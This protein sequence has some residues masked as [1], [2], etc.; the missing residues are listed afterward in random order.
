MQ[1][2]YFPEWLSGNFA[3]V[4]SWTLIHSLW[5][6]LIAAVSAGL[7]LTCTRHSS[8]QL[9][10]NLLSWIFVLFLLAA[11][12]VFFIEYGTPEP[13]SSALLANTPS[14]VGVTPQAS[15]PAVDLFSSKA[16]SFE[17]QFISFFNENAGIIVLIW[18]FFLLVRSMKVIKDIWNAYRLNIVDV[19]TPSQSWLKK[20]SRLKEKLEI[21]KK[22]RLLES[23]RI[24]VPMTMGY[25]KATILVPIG[26]LA[27]LPS[28]QV[29]AILLH[30]LAHIKRKDFIMNFMQ[31]IA[32]TVFFFNPAVLWISSKIREEREAC[33]DDVVVENLQEK[34]S[35]LEALISFQEYTM[36]TGAYAIGLVGGKN[37]LLTRVKRLLTSENKKLDA[38]EKSILILC[39]FAITAFSFIPRDSYD[40]K[41]QT[42]LQNDNILHPPSMDTTKVYRTKEHNHTD[43]VPFKKRLKPKPAD[44]GSEFISIVYDRTN[45]PGD[46]IHT[47]EITDRNADKFTIT[48]QNSHMVALS[49]NG[50]PIAAVQLTA[51]QNLF[52]RAEDFIRQRSAEKSK[53]KLTQAEDKANNTLI[54]NNNAGKKDRAAA[55]GQIE[56]NAAKNKL[57]SNNKKFDTTIAVNLKKKELIPDES[58]KRDAERIKGVLQELVNEGVVSNTSLVEWFGITDSKMMVNGIEVPEALHNKLKSKY[59]IENKK[60]LFYG[61]S[62]LHGPGIHFDKKDLN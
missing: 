58:W 11:G 55:T 17:E 39:V 36:G 5:L 60:G 15:I 37:F 32:E 49:V 38:V 21:S 50:N 20:L 14:L 7:V 53:A 48:K 4:L 42:G 62:Q 34:R 9:R 13:S 46:P 1:L 43:T 40:M 26:L 45:D 6:G 25:L 12:T 41:Q 44:P 24:K 52:K 27:N 59:G 30:E 56:Y 23:R 29:E 10:Y 47:Y 22:V 51:Y 8:A 54:V 28:D 33:C 57:E 31:S 35:Y 16:I 3:K 19:H 18:F 61:P 2:L